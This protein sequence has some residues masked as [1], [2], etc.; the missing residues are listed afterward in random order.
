MKQSNI[1]SPRWCQP[2]FVEPPGPV[3]VVID[4]CF[5]ED[6]A[7][8]LR[9]GKQLFELEV[10]ET[11]SSQSKGI[12][13][14]CCR[15]PIGMRD[16]LKDLVV[17]SETAE[18]IS[19]R[20]V[21][22]RRGPIHSVNMVFT[23][24]WHLL[25]V[26][27]DGQLEDQSERCFNLVQELNAMQPDLVIHTGDLITRYQG[28][29]LPPLPEADIRGQFTRAREIFDQLKIPMFLLPGNHDLGFEVCRRHWWNLV[30]KPW[31]GAT[32][33]VSVLLGPV[34]FL[35]VDGFMHYDPDTYHMIGRSMTGGQLAWLE[36]SLAETPAS[37]RVIAI[38]Y[39]YSDQMMPRLRELSIDAIFYGH[40]KA[41]DQAIFDSAGTLNG[42]LPGDMAYRQATISAEHFDMGPPV[43]FEALGTTTEKGT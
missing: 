42:H 5:G 22:L 36:S 8:F 16:G 29:G 14:F 13:R 24:D 18:Q 4:D 11:Q 10:L 21:V 6:V 3:A 26:G 38:H 1:R 12:R 35:M 25:L 28:S 9:D 31:R 7:F 17:R 15:A 33:D 19:L 34:H 39:D 2:Q 20:S 27:Q 37:R 40:G 41:K 23:S 32:D 30:G 43:S